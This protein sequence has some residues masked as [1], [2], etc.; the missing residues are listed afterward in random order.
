MVNCFLVCLYDI[1]AY[2]LKYLIVFV[3]AFIE[4]DIIIIFKSKECWPTFILL[5]GIHWK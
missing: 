4:H 5:L 2:C 3:V 1:H